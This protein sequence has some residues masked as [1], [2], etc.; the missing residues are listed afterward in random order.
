MRKEIFRTLLIFTI[1]IAAVLY[2]V[3]ESRYVLIIAL[4]I[5]CF[6]LILSWSP[7]PR[8]KTFSDEDRLEATSRAQ[9]GGGFPKLW[10]PPIP[11]GKRRKKKQ[12]PR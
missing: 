6:L 4:G 5:V 7:P 12:E 3:T 8:H 11:G 10:V 9:G 1:L 2:F